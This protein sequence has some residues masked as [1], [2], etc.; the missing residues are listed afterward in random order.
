MA[1]S[2]RRIGAEDSASRTQLLDAAEKLLLTEGY[3]AVTSRKVAAAAGLKPQLVHYYFR[4]MD[5]LFVALLRRSAEL[6]LAHFDK[7]IA[8]DGSLA[9]LWRLNSD[10]RGSAFMIELAALAN[11]RKEIRSELAA[12][13]ERF[14]KAQLAALRRALVAEGVDA[15]AEAVLLLAT[16]LSQIIGIEKNLGM[17]TGHKTTIAFVNDLLARL[18]D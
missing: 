2:E 12:Y 17:T 7:E 18:A 5:D 3:A 13:A 6:N 11:H 16:G 14:R 10:P 9:N 4:T 8:R 15:P 1:V